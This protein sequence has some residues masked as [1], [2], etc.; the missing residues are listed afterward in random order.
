MVAG[1]Q[2]T[3]RRGADGATGV[4]LCEPHTTGGEPIDIG[5]FDFRLAVAAQIAV[6]KIVCQKKHD[7]RTFCRGRSLRFLGK[8]KSE[9]RERKGG[10]DIRQTARSRE[11]IHKVML[12]FKKMTDVRLPENHSI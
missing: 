12:A 4:K 9:D 7:I 5:G 11:T 3:P 2:R 8:C 1:H 6:A 10:D